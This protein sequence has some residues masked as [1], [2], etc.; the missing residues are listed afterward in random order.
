MGRDRDRS[1]T[2]PYGH[3]DTGGPVVD[4][5]AIADRAAQAEVAQHAND[6]QNEGTACR[7]WA[8]YGEMEKRMRAVENE[9]ATARG[10][11]LEAGRAAGLRSALVTSL[12]VVAA[13][14]GLFLAARAWPTHAAQAQAAQVKP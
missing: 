5:Q 3:E 6:C 2:H 14:V 4:V 8:A 12:I 10:T 11:A 7:L 13:Q 9:Q 1:L